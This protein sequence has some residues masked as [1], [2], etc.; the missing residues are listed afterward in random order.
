MNDRSMH[1][2][3]L[4]PAFVEGAL[5][6]DDEAAV[7]AH[8]ASCEACRAS[9][10]AFTALEASLVSRR[11][12][13]PPLERFLPVFETRPA[14]ARASWLIRAFRSAMSPAGVA[15][16]LAAWVALLALRYNGAIGRVF[17]LSTPDHLT[18]G[19]D[20]VADVLVILTN[21]NVS[22]LIAGLTVVSLGIAASMGAM[23][24]RFIRH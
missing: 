4:L 21:G 19:I 3:S 17:S 5:G 10:E 24:L 8:V 11:S 7:R 12:E 14:T 1:V 9:L 13:I 2:E 6:A 16:V 20:R 22:L 18:G 15:L 23:T